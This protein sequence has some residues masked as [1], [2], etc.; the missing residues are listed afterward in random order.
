M[1]R[2]EEAKNRAFA[3]L[4]RMQARVAAHLGNDEAAI[5]LFQSSLLEDEDYLKTVYSY[6]IDSSTAEYAVEQ[7]ERVAA[8]F[9]ASLDNSYLRSRSADITDVSRRL[10]G[11]LS[12]QEDL[13]RLRQIPAILVAEELTPSETALL[14]S[15]ILLGL[16]SRNSSP[17]SHLAILARSIGVPALIGME[18]DPKWEGHMAILDAD[19]GVLIVDPDEQTLSQVKPHRSFERAGLRTENLTIPR[20]AGG[21]GDIRL[22]AVIDSAWEAADA[23]AVGASA[24]AVYRTDFLFGERKTPPVEEEQFSEYRRTVEAMRNRPVVIQSVE[25][26]PVSI[27][28]NLNRLL[29]PERYDRLKTQLRAILRAAQGAQVSIAL[30][31]VHTG[32]DIRYGRQMLQTCRNELKAEG[33]DCGEPK[34]GVMAD[35]P[36]EVFIA[37]ILAEKAEMIVLD[38]EAL[39]QSTRVGRRDVPDYRVLGQMLRF[40]VAAAHRHDCQ[41]IM[42]GDM[43]SF[44]QAI[45]PLLKLGI[46]GLSVPV[47]SLRNLYD[48]CRGLPDSMAK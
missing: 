34:L 40:A 32:L 22:C 37:D 30:S 41:I 6:I 45:H 29:H 14:D 15:G 12:K 36:S 38:G 35:R 43:E 13:G 3:D 17:D 25:V 10:T 2:F 1:L 18:V 7:A 31:G 5:F 20:F 39:M 42:M 46:D 28:G 19:S 8:G 11:I 47:R 26:G 44:P 16:V 9:F 4:A 23:Y 48:Y 21:G 33:V 27:N 24:V